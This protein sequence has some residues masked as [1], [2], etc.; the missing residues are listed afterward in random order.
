M[1]KRVLVLV[2]L[3]PLPVFLLLVWSLFF[4]PD[5]FNYLVVYPDSTFYI[6]MA[7]RQHDLVHYP[8]RARILVPFLASLISPMP[9]AV[10]FFVVNSL[11]MV[12]VSVAL[13]YFFRLYVS[14]KYAVLGVFCHNLSYPIIFYFFAALTDTV[15]YL[16]MVLGLYLIYTKRTSLLVVV[17]LSV[18]VF[19][20]ETVLILLPL[21]IFSLYR[22][23]RLREIILSVIPIAIFVFQYGLGSHTVFHLPFGHWV[24]VLVFSLAPFVVFVW[25]WKPKPADVVYSVSVIALSVFA[26]FFAYFDGRFLVLGY[27]VWIGLTLQV[28]K[29]WFVSS[30][31]NEAQSLRTASSSPTTDDST[32]ALGPPSF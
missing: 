30:S 20:R 21:W 10:S 26:M 23:H 4:A 22:V 2:A 31:G 28:L 25:F 5:L 11:T 27:P 12:M 16:F 32:G 13:F 1:R 14:D 8:F 24:Q 9:N 6:L 3:A 17:V 15:A 29:K 18:G 19:A 7:N